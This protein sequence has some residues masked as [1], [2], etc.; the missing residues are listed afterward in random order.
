MAFYEVAPKQKRLVLTTFWRFGLACLLSALI[1]LP[2]AL[3]VFFWGALPVD[4]VLRA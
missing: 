2:Y 1:F 4:M 3:I